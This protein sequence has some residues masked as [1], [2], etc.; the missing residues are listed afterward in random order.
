MATCIGTR[1]RSRPSVGNII[2]EYQQDQQQ[3]QQAPQ[4]T[5]RSTGT[6]SGHSGSVVQRGSRLSNTTPERGGGFRTATNAPAQPQRKSGTT[7][8]S[9]G[10]ASGS[11]AA[12]TN[13]T[14]NRAPVQT[15][16]GSRTA[17]ATAGQASRSRA[18]VPFITISP[19]EGQ[20][21]VARIQRPHFINSSLERYLQAGT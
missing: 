1:V 3:Q 19:E 8:T 5:S 2:D 15:Q 17:K 20:E 10:Q 21:I 6:A 12:A 7:S 4:Q 9:V 16:R 13:A 18:R 11:R 14:Q